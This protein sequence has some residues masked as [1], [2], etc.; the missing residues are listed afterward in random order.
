MAHLPR[1]TFGPLALIHGYL[2]DPMSWILGLTEEYHF[3]S[4]VLGFGED[5]REGGGLGGK[6]ETRACQQLTTFKGG[7]AVLEQRGR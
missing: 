7:G 2:A 6:N 1:L 3:V 4:A 5:G